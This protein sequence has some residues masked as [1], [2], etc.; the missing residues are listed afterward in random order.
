MDFITAT[1]R[2]LELSLNIMFRYQDKDPSLRF[3]PA[4][5]V[6]TASDPVFQFEPETQRLGGWRLGCQM[7]K[8]GTWLDRQGSD[9]SVCGSPNA[10]CEGLVTYL[11]YA[12]CRVESSVQVRAFS[13]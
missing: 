9:A 12:I 7:L 4:L 5:P 6:L 3:S 10:L 2:K 11:R 8:F 13:R 1:E